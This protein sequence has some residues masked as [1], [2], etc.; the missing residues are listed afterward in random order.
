[1][2]E[3]ST[4]ALRRR[5]SKALT[6]AGL[7]LEPGTGLVF[8]RDPTITCTVAG[9]R[10]VMFSGQELSVSQAARRPSTPWATPGPR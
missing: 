5:R 10:T 8:V 9:P 4:Q 7:G 6:L 2:V 1:M 3:G